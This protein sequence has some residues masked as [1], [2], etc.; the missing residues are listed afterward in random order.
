MFE[1]DKDIQKAHLHKKQEDYDEAIDLYIR[2]YQRTKRPSGLIFAASCDIKQ[3]NFGEALERYEKLFREFPREL[4]E[5]YN[6]LIYSK[7]LLEEKK[8]QKTYD[9]LYQLKARIGSK[10]FMQLVT[11]LGGKISANDIFEKSKFEINKPN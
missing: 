5:E 6:V 9:L 11:Y 8:F 10:V 4:S 2:Y 1:N 7:C 3:G